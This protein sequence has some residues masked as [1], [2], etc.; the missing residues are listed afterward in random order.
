MDLGQ[1]PFSPIIDERLR[2]GERDA[3]RRDPLAGGADGAAA[4]ASAGLLLLLL[5]LL[6]QHS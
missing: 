6:P 1:T 5:L 3:R 2:R 4:I